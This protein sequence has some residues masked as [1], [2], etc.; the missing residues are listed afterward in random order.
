MPGVSDNRRRKN[1]VILAIALLLAVTVLGSCYFLFR[2]EGDTVR[3]TVGR[4]LFGTYS[5]DTDRVVEIRTGDA[6][7]IL[8]IRDGRAYMETASCPDGICTAHRPI[9]RDGESI[10]CLPNRVVVTV[11]A[12]RED[13]PDIVA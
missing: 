9:S 3:V 8:V 10:V 4:E 11:L 2:G 13:A 1:D 5:L 6:L 7:N 12:T